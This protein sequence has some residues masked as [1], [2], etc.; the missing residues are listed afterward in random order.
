MCKLF[1][2]KQP[3]FNILLSCF[4]LMYLFCFFLKDYLNSFSLIFCIFLGSTKL[5]VV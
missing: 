5:G 4:D 3:L 1:T 2:T